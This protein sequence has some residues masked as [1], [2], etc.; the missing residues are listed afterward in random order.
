MAHG[1]LGY[2]VSEILEDRRRTLWTGYPFN[3]EAVSEFELV[4]NEITAFV[5]PVYGTAF[6]L[7][8]FLLLEN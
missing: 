4:R 3:L 6:A 7:T 1:K 2:R 8:L 5:A